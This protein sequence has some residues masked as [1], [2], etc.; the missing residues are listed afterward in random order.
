MT[1]FLM[2]LLLAGGPLMADDPAK[3]LA[4]LEGLVNTWT[5][6]RAEIASE[7]REWAEQRKFLLAE[8][9][10][11]RGEVDRL[12]GEIARFREFSTAEEREREELLQQVETL[13]A[14][15]EDL[16]P[17]LTRLEER[18]RSLSSGMPS[19]MQSDF[20]SIVAGFPEVDAETSSSRVVDRMQS[21]ASALVFVEELHPQLHVVREMLEVGE[22]SRREM[23]VLY[24][25]LARAFAVSGSNDW[26][27]VG[28]PTPSGW[29]WNARPELASTIRNA[30]EISRQR[31]SAAFL[32][33]PFS[34]L[35][36]GESE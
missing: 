11:L 7:K 29:V 8:R 36:V 3:S 9:D 23:D 4:T 32:E 20:E 30:I 22:D 12:S 17:V 34:L 19:P 14:T 35:N 25:G 21:V 33:L 28:T 1:L 10:L 5:R 31:G 26:A 2:T 27:G 6:L 13:S 15:L 24:I 16:E 18:I